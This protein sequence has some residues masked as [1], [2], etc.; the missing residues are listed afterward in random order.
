MNPDERRIGVAGL[1]A[2]LPGVRGLRRLNK[3][4]GGGDVATLLGYHWDAAPGTVVAQDVSIVVPEDVGWWLRTKVYG[5]RQVYRAASTDVQLGSAQYRRR[6][7]C[8]KEEFSFAFPFLCLSLSFLLPFAVCSST[9]L[10]FLLLLATFLSC[11][12]DPDNSRDHESSPHESLS[13]IVLSE[14]GE[15]KIFKVVSWSARSNEV[16][17]LNKRKVSLIEIMIRTSTLYFLSVLKAS[18][19]LSLNVFNSSNFSSSFNVEIFFLFHTVIIFY[20]YLQ[21]EYFLSV[22]EN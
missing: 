8:D 14:R 19:V 5:A 4:P 2:V 6:R 1:A 11:S 15:W 10:L 12:L 21:F 13:G 22:T 17:L 18:G 9:S 20:I 7:Y 16:E 3:E